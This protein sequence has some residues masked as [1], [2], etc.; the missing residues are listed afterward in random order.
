MSASGGAGCRQCLPLTRRAGRRWCFAVWVAAGLVAGFVLPVRRAAAGAVS[1]CSHPVVFAG[2]AVNVVVL[3]YS[4][5]QVSLDFGKAGRQL[6]LL[7]QLDSLFVLGKYGSLGTAYL[8]AEPFSKCEEERVEAQLLAGG[9]EGRIAS[10]RALVVLWGRIYEEGGD[11]YLQSYLRFLRRDRADSVELPVSGSRAGSGRKV[12]PPRAPFI[13][14]GRSPSQQVAFPPRRLGREDLNA[15]EEQ[16]KKAAQLY[17]EPQESAAAGQLPIDANGTLAYS[18]DEVRDGWL[19]VAS[20]S[21][22]SPRWL[23]ARIDPVQWPLHRKMPELDFLDAVTGYLQARIAA[24]SADRPGGQ[25]ALGEWMRRVDE[26]LGR[27][28]DAAGSASPLVTGLGNVLAGNLRLLYGQPESALPY[29]HRAAQEIPYSADARNLEIL[30]QL[31]RRQQ[32]NG[33]PLEGGLLDALALE[34]G[35]ADVVRNL[36]TFYELELAD[37][38]S[39]PVCGSV[40]AAGVKRKLAAVNQVLASLNAP[41]PGVTDPRQR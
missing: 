35:N 24:E 10:G 14:I 18:V 6:A 37:P 17:R 20:G 41:Q 26:A 12:P 36:K 33:L 25:A 30:P 5:D 40:D 32:R 28:A 7:L 21:L 11:V 1:P 38:P 8:T 34:P 15:I 27:Y 29:Y 2:A 39:C 3:P 23:R 16:F 31:V 19:H 4:A 13:F 9:G 22:D